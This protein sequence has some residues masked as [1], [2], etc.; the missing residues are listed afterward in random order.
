MSIKKSK[1]NKSMRFLTSTAHTDSLLFSIFRKP[2]TISVLM[3]ML[4]MLIYL[5][6]FYR[7]KSN[8]VTGLLVSFIVFVVVGTLFYTDGIFERPHPVL[9]RGVKACSVYYLMVMVFLLFQDKHNVRLWLKY[10]DPSLGVPLPERSYATHCDLTFTNLYNQMDIFV[11]A[12]IFGWYFKAI[13]FRDYFLCWILS[14]MFEVMEYSLQHQLPNFAECWWDHWILDVFTCNALGIHLGIKTCQYFNAKLYRWRGNVDPGFVIYEWLKGATTFKN[15]I[16]IL[17]LVIINIA[18]ELNTFYLKA[19]LYL[20]PSHFLN[21]I[22]L[23][24]HVLM[25]AVA[26]REGYSYFS[27][28]SVKTFGSQVWICLACTLVETL[29]CFKY[30]KGEFSNPFPRNVIIFWSFLMAAVIVYPILRYKM[31]II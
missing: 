31:R 18:I 9:W 14:V 11:V 17:I 10:I 1:K 16:G 22:R 8:V 26:L 29:V 5:A 15:Y 19:L 21:V 30:G 27:D 28:R 12:H 24:I 2:H 3:A 7:C 4:S 25:G 13:I 23:V 20:P 6:F